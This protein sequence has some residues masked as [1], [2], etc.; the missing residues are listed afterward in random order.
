MP[1]TQL[2]LRRLDISA[3]LQLLYRMVTDD[4]CSLADFGRISQDM[5]AVVSSI[6]VQ[7]IPHLIF[8]R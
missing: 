5:A 7:K 1:F 4:I 8:R 2:T 6:F 3:F